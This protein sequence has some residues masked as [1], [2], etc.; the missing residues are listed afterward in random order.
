[1]ALSAKSLRRSIDEQTLNS[2]IPVQNVNAKVQAYIPAAKSYG[3]STWKPS[4][5]SG[6]F[7][8]RRSLDVSLE[9]PSTVPEHAEATENSGWNASTSSEISWASCSTIAPMHIGLP[10]VTESLSSISVEPAALSPNF[11]FVHPTKALEFTDE[12]A[13]RVTPEA[14]MRSILLDDMDHYCVHHFQRAALAVRK[15]S[16]VPCCSFSTSDSVTV[17]YGTIENASYLQRRHGFDEDCSDSEII[18]KLYEKTKFSFLSSL[19]GK[20]TIIHYSG[21]E[22]QVFAVTDIS[23]SH[24]VLQGQDLT[25]GLAISDVDYGSRYSF[26]E[27]PAASFIFGR[28]RGRHIHKYAATMSELEASKEVAVAAVDRALSGLLVPSTQRSTSR[29]ET[30]ALWRRTKSTP[31]Q[32]H[33]NAVKERS[34]RIGRADLAS[35]WRR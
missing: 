19:R 28:H 11:V 18:C 24:C 6:E 14:S 22:D 25:G 3:T 21:V 13:V 32:C 20:F 16:T 8:R 29:S 4:R 10:L 1:M 26:S 33:S 9:P 34:T 2:L 30:P 15:D 23:R 27:V 17:V 31:L 5:R 7:S 35:S 12:G